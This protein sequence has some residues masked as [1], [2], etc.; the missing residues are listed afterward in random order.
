MLTVYLRSVVAALTELHGHNLAH[1]DV[2]LE[3]ICFDEAN[4]AVFI[5]LD[6][7][8]QADS[9]VSF[10][11]K[12]LMYTYVESWTYKQWDWRQ[13]GLLLVRVLQ[14]VSSAEE[15]HTKEPDFRNPSLEHAFLRTLY[16]DGKNSVMQT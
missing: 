10:K 2:R 14:P 1:L 15:Y 12:S 6:R 7:S 11:R 5:D 16:H 9:S 3:N 8:E 13:L 4:R